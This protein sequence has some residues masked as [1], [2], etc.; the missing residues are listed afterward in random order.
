MTTHYLEF[1]N[2]RGIERRLRGL[3]APVEEIEGSF[4][5]DGNRLS[6]ATY[7][8]AKRAID[9]RALKSFVASEAGA[10]AWGLP[11]L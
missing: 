3:P 7:R 4:Y 11:G 1:P 2:Q 10:D 8:F 6:G 5:V 9:N